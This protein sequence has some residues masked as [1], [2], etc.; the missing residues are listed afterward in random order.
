MANVEDPS[1]SRP[2]STQ[3]EGAADAMRTLMCCLHAAIYAGASN[4]SQSLGTLVHLFTHRKSPLSTQ[5]LA[6]CYT[7]PESASIL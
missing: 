3:K 4:S 1:H 6:S 5:F 7:T 2:F